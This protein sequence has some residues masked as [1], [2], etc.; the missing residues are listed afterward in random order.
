LLHTID[1]FQITLKRSA[2][3]RREVKAEVRAEVRAKMRADVGGEVGA[4]VGA[5]LRAEVGAERT[6]LSQGSYEGVPGVLQ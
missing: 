2:G 1:R 4:E 5:E 3:V 6:K